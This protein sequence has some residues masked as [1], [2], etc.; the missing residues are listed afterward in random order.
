MRSFPWDSVVT[1]MGDDGLPK[2][3]RSS[4][5]DD[6]REII[7][8]FLTDGVFMGT[9]SSLQVMA[10]DAMNVTVKAGKCMV[11]STVGVELEDR[12]LA[13][14][15]SDSTYDRID[16]VVARWN[17]NVEAR[18][19]ELYVVKG[20]PAQTPTRPTLNRS[21]S[22]WELGLADVYVP[23]GTSAITQQRITD[24]RLE[25]E[26]CGA[27]TPYLDF[28][29]DTWFDQIQDQVAQNLELIE[30]AIDGTLASQLQQ[31]ID[32]NEAG[33][34][35]K[36]QENEERWS[37]LEILEITPEPNRNLLNLSDSAHNCFVFG[38]IAVFT[39]IVAFKA[40]TTWN[41]GDIKI[42]TLPGYARPASKVTWPR[43]ARIVTTAD[44]DVYRSA[45]VESDGSVKVSNTS[46][47]NGVARV[48]IVSYVADV[49]DWIIDRGVT[50]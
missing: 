41:A 39:L 17:T 44:G 10:G 27:V 16:T 3:D 45:S 11:K 9:S 30:A 21:A 20:T 29:T 31:Q 33:N 35:S 36:W 5:A 22:V 12:T 6:V 19:I 37:G 28:P 46:A 34:A 38:E 32:E 23:A 49:H 4:N 47:V 25:T 24:T 13:L 48:E 8:T 42:F 43:C 14:Q 15:G 7:G 18:Y 2:Y 1:Q 40:G 26:R 50:Q